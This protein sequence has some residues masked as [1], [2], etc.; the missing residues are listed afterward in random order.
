MQNQLKGEPRNS[1]FVLNPN[2]VQ[3]HLAG[4]PEGRSQNALQSYYQNQQAAA[5]GS[6]QL[7]QSKT[8]RASFGTSAISKN[9]SRYSNLQNYGYQ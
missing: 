7:H 3:Q 5:A 6:R 2:A 4:A 1:E 9:Q 8:H